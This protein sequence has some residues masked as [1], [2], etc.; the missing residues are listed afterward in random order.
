MEN[1]LVTIIIVAVLTFATA[2]LSKAAIGSVDD[3][4][5]SWKAME[6][7]SGDRARTQVTVTDAET[8]VTGS[9]VYISLRNDGQSRVLDFSRMDVILQYFSPGG[10]YNTAWIPYTDGALANNEWTVMSISPDVFEPGILNP[11]E[12][13]TIQAKLSP[14]V[15]TGTTN[16]ATVATPNGISLTA[17]FVH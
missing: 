3:L 16:W 17:Y 12:E 14:T 2:T 9:N 6:M 13:L 4:G 10:V 15:G 5:Q 8:D 1:A 7:V 11:G